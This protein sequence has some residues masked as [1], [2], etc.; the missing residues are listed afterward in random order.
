MSVATSIHNHQPIS[1][2]KKCAVSMQMDFDHSWLDL[3]DS[4]SGFFGLGVYPENSIPIRLLEK[5]TQFI[6]RPNYQCVVYAKGSGCA[7][8]TEATRSACWLGTARMMRSDSR[9]LGQLKT[10]ECRVLR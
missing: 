9:N 6:S 1:G 5:I 8:R 7:E 10:N 2:D 4:S 3:V